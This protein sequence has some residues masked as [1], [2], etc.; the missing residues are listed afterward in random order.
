M[1][2]SATEK[3]IPA[4]IEESI[5]II[6]ESYVAFE[7]FKNSISFDKLNLDFGIVSI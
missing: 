6:K 7:C 3:N 5:A 2:K 1:I 4:C